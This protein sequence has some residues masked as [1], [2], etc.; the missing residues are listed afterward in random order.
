MKT[1][2]KIVIVF[3]CGVLSLAAHAQSTHWSINAYD[4][5]YDM[6]VFFTLENNGVAVAD[7]DSYEVAAFVGD[8]CRGVGGYVSSETAG[9]ET[10]T[11]GYQRV[12]SNS[13]SGE[14]VT[15]KVYDK[16]LAKEYDVEAYSL[17][18]QSQAVVGMPSSPVVF[19]I[20]DYY[21]ILVT[22]SDETKGVVTGGATV[23]HGENVTV[24]ATA[25][26]GYHFVNWTSGETVVSTDAA[27]TFS[28][29]GDVSLVANFV[30]NQY[31]MT[32]V[33]DNGQENIVKVQ[34]FNSALTAPA[35]PVKE[36]F[37]FTGWSSEV[38]AT[39]PAQDMTFTAQWERN[40]YTL[41]FVVDGVTVKEES[42]L[43]EATITAPE[44]PTMEGYTFTGW[45]PAV[46]ETMPAHDVTCT[47]QFQINQY[48]MTF[49][50]D[51]GQ[52]N[53]VKVQDFNSVLT[54][55]A[56][57][58]KEGFTF[59]GWSPEV[60]ATVPAKDMTFTA[61]YTVNTYYVI[62]IVN[63]EEWARD[64][65]AY[66]APIVLREYPVEAG[67]TFSGW[68]SDATYETMPAHDVVY[69]A[70]LATGLAG[71]PADVKFVN[72]YHLNGTLLYRHIPTEQIKEQLPKGVYIIL[73][74][75]YVV[76]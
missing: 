53:I 59:T 47:A 51:N 61:Q 44:D 24:T 54:A 18:F 71:I 29:S 22:S 28:A 3:L 56:D 14:T 65:V 21:T 70:E 49:V 1:L 16:A 76:K 68:V 45:N 11:Y 17:T 66:G 4:Y 38:P 6:T 63:G 10:V 39:V 23:K 25:N 48:T 40:S 34:D 69:T 72:V 43:F 41:K 73:G 26:E 13:S 7:L 75:K 32:F 67:Y 36:G 74:K 27:Y 20:F 12:H 30:P 64:P 60:P 46:P 2:D 52:E 58:V 42:V 15:F 33:L 8:E 9:G 50:L 35:D 5:Q 31:T 62:Y 19:A 57:P 37:T 55:P